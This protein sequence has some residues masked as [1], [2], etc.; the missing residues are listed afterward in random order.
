MSIDVDAIA[1]NDLFKTL[2][3][4]VASGDLVATSIKEARTLAPAV[5][6][7]GRPDV[8]GTDGTTIPGT[9]A[10]EMFLEDIL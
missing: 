9:E 4:S 8:V 7:I 10:E 1:K 2:G 3:V 5:S 6:A